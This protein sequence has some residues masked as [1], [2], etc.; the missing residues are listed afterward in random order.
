MMMAKKSSLNSGQSLIELLVAAGIF[1]LV[2][3]A[4]VTALI[5]GQIAN[6][7]AS[8]NAIALSLAQEGLEA[9]RSIRDNSWADLTTGSHGLAISANR[10]VFQGTSEDLSLKLRNANRIVT[11][12]SAGSNRMLAQVAINWEIMPGRQ[13]KTEL[14]A[15]LTNWKIVQATE[16][17]YLTIDATAAT[18]T[19][20]N[21]RL[22]GITLLNTSPTTAITIDKITLTWNN[23]RL[24]QTAILG[25]TTVWSRTGPGTPSGRQ[26]SATVLDIQDYQ[27]APTVL[28]TSEFRFNNNMNGAVFSI[29][30]TMLDGSQKTINNIAP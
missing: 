10:W 25:T 7:Q 24:I 5:G 19:N 26:P 12:S 28:S 23:S 29:T 6:L 20:G 17:D 3:S 8:Q 27:L 11:I 1:I 4:A 13:A 21:R 14:S 18:L 15:Y 16:A 22:K 9:A 2:A 30:V